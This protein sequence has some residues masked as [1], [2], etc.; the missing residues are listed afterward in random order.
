MILHQVQ[1]RQFK[2]LNATKNLA[3]KAAK[4]NPVEALKDE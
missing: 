1:D 3:S 2:W 4:L